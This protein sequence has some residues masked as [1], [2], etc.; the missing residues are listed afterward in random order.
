MPMSAPEAIPGNW[1]QLRQKKCDPERVWQ[2]GK[3]TPE[4][5][6][7]CW[8][9]RFTI[10]EYFAKGVGNLAK[11]QRGSRDVTKFSSLP[12]QQILHRLA[13]FFKLFQSGLEFLLPEGI[14]LQ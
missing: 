4:A 13:F 10:A 5:L 14:E 1:E 11:W 7:L 2:S 6:E 3:D 8:A 9:K 12:R